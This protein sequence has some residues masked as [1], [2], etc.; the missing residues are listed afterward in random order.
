MALLDLDTLGPQLKG[1]KIS[2]LDPELLDSVLELAAEHG[3]ITIASSTNLH[4]LIQIYKAEHSREKKDIERLNKAENLILRLAGLIPLHHEES[5]QAE[6]PRG[7]AGRKALSNLMTEG[8]VMI[9]RKEQELFE[10]VGITDEREM[11]KAVGLLGQE[12]IAQRVRLALSSRLGPQLAKM[13]F[14]E[15]PSVLSTPKDGDF[16]VELRAMENKKSLID[17]WAGVSGEPLP[18]WA[19]YMESPNVLLVHYANLYRA[20]VLGSTGKKAAE[21]AAGPENDT[22]V[23]KMLREMGLSIEEKG[24]SLRLVCPDG[25]DLWVSQPLD[26][27][28]SHDLDAGGRTDERTVPD[29]PSAIERSKSPPRVKH[30]VSDTSVLSEIRKMGIDVTRLGAEL[31]RISDSSDPV[32]RSREQEKFEKGI[33]AFHE[34][35]VSGRLEEAI[36]RHM[37][38]GSLL[39]S[40]VAYLTGANGAFEISLSDEKGS[41]MKRLYLHLQDM[42]PARIGKNIAEAEGL[43]THRIWVEPGVAGFAVSEDAREVGSRG[44][45][46]IRMPGTF[47]FENAETVAAAVFKEDIALRPDPQNAMHAG[48]Y[49]KISTPEGRTEVLGALAAYFEMSRR[50]LLPDRR[51]SNTFILQVMH[52]GRKE[53]TFQPTDMDGIG[54]FI[55]VKGDAPDFSDFNHDFHKAAADFAVQMHEGMVRAAEKGMIRGEIAPPSQI[56]SEMHSALKRFPLD[57]ARVNE[58]RIGLLRDNDGKPIGIGFDAS[59]LVDHTVP[60]QGGRSRIIRKRRP[61]PFGCGPGRADVDSGGQQGRAG[62]IPRRIPDWRAQIPRKDA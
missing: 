5:R 20:L 50:A 36:I 30:R 25:R 45:V 4:F 14:G 39:I 61:R 52:G 49:D 38:G 27:G 23:I 15:N 17:K 26:I 47:R 33:A 32:S 55:D 28:Q 53:F 2:Q 22:H 9:G 3:E 13:V 37:D 19:N 11:Q 35:L 59:A 34:L 41:V 51:P 16:E 46:S 24:G 31:D 56:L 21:F 40:K 29:V 58:E 18:I 8:G 54:N 42:E 60:S 1:I 10:S 12:K 57:D 48:Y 44:P 7:F 62:R 43:V 6:A